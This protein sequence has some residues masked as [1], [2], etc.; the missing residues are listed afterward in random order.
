MGETHYYDDPDADLAPQLSPGEQLKRERDA[1]GL[2]QEEVATSLNL[3]PAVVRGLEN[4]DYNEVPVATYR[5][6]YLR[7]Y[8]HL[9]GISEQP[10]IAAYNAQFGTLDTEQKVTPVHV[11]K[12]PSRLGPWLFKLV[13]VLVIVGLIGLTLL[14]WQS[15]SGNDLLGLSDSEPVA[16]DTMEGDSGGDDASADDSESAAASDEEG[17]GSDDL[18]PLPEEDGEMGLVEDDTGGLTDTGELDET[19]SDEDSSSDSPADAS[20]REDDATDESELVTSGSDVNLASGSEDTADDDDSE[21]SADDDESQETASR[22]DTDDETSGDDTQ[23]R[24]AGRI[25]LSFEEESWTEIFDAND[26]RIFFGLQEAGSQA[27]AEGEPPFRMTIG[28]A[29]G[30]ELRYL[31]ETIDLEERTG[32]NN[33]ARFTLDDE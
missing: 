32:S 13:T 20:D 22:S 4:D 8:A 33:V 12:P 3:R 27:T 15:R 23:E 2:S 25:E 21:S 5:R 10:I 18:P 24:N 17:A 1:Q 19:T 9:L 11:T 30:V 7:A 16:V 29:S 31:G 28:N 26:E 14:W 6:G